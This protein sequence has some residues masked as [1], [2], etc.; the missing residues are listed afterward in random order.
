M[1]PRLPNSDRLAVCG[2]PDLGVSPMRDAIRG[3]AVTLDELVAKWETRVQSSLPG[4]LVPVTAVSD[5]VL[6]DLR[7][8]EAVQPLGRGYSTEAAARILGVSAKTVA[9]WCQA[10]R[11]PAA[12]KTG[13]A[14]G[15]KWVI[16]A[17]TLHNY[18]LQQ[19]GGTHAHATSAD[20]LPT[21]T[22]VVR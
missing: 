16:P 20:V 5:E 7:A 18:Q 3:H 13:N 10:G 12:S 22:R 2:T 21:G 8:L 11:F 1:V 6:Q 14:R 15:G 4:T 9:Q 17:T 19:H